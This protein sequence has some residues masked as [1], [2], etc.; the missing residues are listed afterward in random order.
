MRKVR[1]AASR[2]GAQLRL[3]QSGCPRRADSTLPWNLRAAHP[4]CGHRIVVQTG[5][6]VEKMK[7]KHSRRDRAS[8]NQVLVC[9]RWLAK[10]AA[11]IVSWPMPPACS[12]ISPRFA[13]SERSD[14][15]SGP[16]ATFPDAKSCRFRNPCGSDANPNRSR[17][18]SH[19][20]INPVYHYS[21][22]TQIANLQVARL[23]AP[24]RKCFS[25]SRRAE[26]MAATSGICRRS[27]QNACPVGA[28][29]A[30]PSC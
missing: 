12:A 2:H 26:S 14:T 30:L 19:A 5:V 24:G 3:H 28:I 27:R 6:Q 10:A 11:P 29:S 25:E 1:I 16:R 8:P 21:C 4:D 13:A 23:A 22:D 17:P 20:D 7:R 9:R 15:G 18:G